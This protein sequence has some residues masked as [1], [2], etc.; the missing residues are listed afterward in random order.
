MKERAGRKKV[1]PN[2]RMLDSI[3]HLSFKHTMHLLQLY[4][5]NPTTPVIPKKR[6]GVLIGTNDRKN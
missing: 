6:N 5:T 2:T 4:K 1:Q 3:L